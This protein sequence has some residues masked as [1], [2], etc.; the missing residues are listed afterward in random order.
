MPTIDKAANQLRL[1]L[2]PKAAVKQESI[3]VPL[4]PTESELATWEKIGVEMYGDGAHGR[5]V[6][7]AGKTGAVGEWLSRV[8]D[9]VRELAKA[10]ADGCMFKPSVPRLRS[11]ATS[12]RSTRRAES[13][14]PAA[15][16][17]S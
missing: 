5:V 13:S 8:S 15:T 7:S 6:Q 2:S 11:R 9:G 12:V 17:A 1:S 14:V 4:Y 16:A 3:A 10:M